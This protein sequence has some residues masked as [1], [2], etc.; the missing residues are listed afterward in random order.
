MAGGMV[1]KGTG[2]EGAEDKNNQHRDPIVLSVD[3][4]PNMWRVSKR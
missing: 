2:A 3:C 4:G 1:D